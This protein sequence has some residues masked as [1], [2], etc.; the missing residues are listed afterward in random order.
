MKKGGW[1]KR[2]NLMAFLPA[3]GKV[4][5]YF[6]IFSPVS[7]RAQARKRRLLAAIVRTAHIVLRAST[8]STARI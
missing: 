1:G 4:F 7:T 6:W 5:L 3:F 2:L 8:A